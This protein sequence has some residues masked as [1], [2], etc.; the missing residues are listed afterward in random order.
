[1]GPNTKQV[2]RINK[3]A[4]I[5]IK[6]DAAATRKL[7]ASLRSYESFNNQPHLRGAKFYAW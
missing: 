7:A 3:Q 4:P 2:Q 1:V 5:Q 6:K